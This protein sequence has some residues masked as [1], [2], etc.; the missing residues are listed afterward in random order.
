MDEK[1]FKH[2]S[3]PPNTEFLMVKGGSAPATFA[4]I[5]VG[6]TGMPFKVA[7]MDR[8]GWWAYYDRAWPFQFSTRDYKREEIPTMNPYNKDNNAFVNVIDVT[9]RF[10]TNIDP[11]YIL[12]D[13]DRQYD[14]ES[15]IEAEDY[16]ANYVV[17]RRDSVWFCNCSDSV[18]RNKICKH[19]RKVIAFENDFRATSMLDR[20]AEPK[21]LGK[22][23]KQLKK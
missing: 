9:P 20:E 13:L 11:D 18:Q 10:D 14:I 1:N 19:I 6:L 7:V 3:Y 22:R 21:T 12:D 5:A 15:T 4:C 23:P 8:N 17:N 2:V 16:V